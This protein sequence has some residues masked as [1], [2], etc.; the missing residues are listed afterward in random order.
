MAISPVELTLLAYQISDR[1]EQVNTF[2]L[3]KMA[4]QIKA[5]GKLD[6][7][8]MHQ[9]E[10][11]ALM[12]NNIEEI[13]QYLMTQTNLALNDIYKVYEKSSHSIYKDVAYLYQAKGVLQKPFKKNTTIQN[14]IESVKKLTRNTFLNMS[15]TTV[16]SKAYRD[17][18]DKAIDTVATGIDD[19]QSVM[20]RVLI[21]KARNGARV[22]YSSGRTRRLDSASR[23]NILE[24]VRQVNYGV[25]EEAGKEY[26][27]DGVEIDAHGLCAED[28]LP[29]QGKQYSLK[30]FEKLQGSLARPIGT[31]NCH[32]SIS[33]IILGVSPRSYSDKELDSLNDY[34][35]KSVKIGDK[36]VSR[37][38]AS[39]LLRK[40]ETNMRYKQDEIVALKT[41]GFDFSD[42]EKQL[43][44]MKAQYK[45][46]TKASGLTP[47]WERAY[48]PGYELF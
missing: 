24:G 28:H 41:A 27:A 34:S 46:I 48:V 38:Q 26:G 47:Q 29:Y 25:R 10:Q 33:Y 8:S 36:E 14:Y 39:Q 23:M 11:M 2:Y 32:H 15:R 44:A 43:R 20:R 22:Q 12:G 37:Y 5:I 35:N 17:A 31:C 9:L 19:Y 45:Y 7:D 3:T 40:A 13:N 18:I 42:E 4:E 6:E 21:D 16:L 30:A 1:F